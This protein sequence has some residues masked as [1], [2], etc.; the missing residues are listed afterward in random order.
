MKIAHT[1][2]RPDASQRNFQSLVVSILLLLVLVADPHL[3]IEHLPHADDLGVNVLLGLRLWLVCLA[4]S[5]NVINR[6][7]EMVLHRRI[8]GAWIY[9]LLWSA[10]VPPAY[11]FVARQIE[12]RWPA[13]QNDILLLI[14]MALVTAFAGTMSQAAGGFRHSHGAV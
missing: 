8:R 14:A 6:L 5:A 4:A 11:G 9:I 2:P 3:F 7:L 1:S 13:A 12:G 10:I